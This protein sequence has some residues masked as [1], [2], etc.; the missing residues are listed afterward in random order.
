MHIGVVIFVIMP[1]L[2]EHDAWFLGCRRVVK[3]DERRAMH[4]LLQNRKILTDT[5]PICFF[6][7][8]LVHAL[9]SLTVRSALLY[10]V[11]PLH[12]SPLVETKLRGSNS[13]AESQL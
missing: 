11:E 7:R 2:I 12:S 6:A 3:V 5:I 13:G 1:Q 8:N 4:L 10:F 9:T